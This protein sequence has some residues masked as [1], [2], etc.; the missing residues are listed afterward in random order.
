MD[1]VRKPIYRHGQWGKYTSGTG[2]ALGNVIAITA[3][4]LRYDQ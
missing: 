3:K 1:P 2:A 4:L